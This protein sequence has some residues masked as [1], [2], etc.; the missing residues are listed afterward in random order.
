[1]ARTENTNVKGKCMYLQQGDCLFFPLKKLP[2]ENELHQIKTNVVQE[3]EATG[4][5][6]RLHDE[7]AVV[8]EHKETK[9]KYLRLLKATPLRHEEHKEIILPPGDYRVG[10][11]REYDHFTEESKSVAD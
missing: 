4:H 3:G 9:T 5:A 10:I 7:D 6:H 11:V 2:S 8:Y 1:M